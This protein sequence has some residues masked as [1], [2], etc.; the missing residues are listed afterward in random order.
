MSLW[1]VLL[2]GDRPVRLEKNE[3]TVCWQMIWGGNSTVR[4]YKI[5]TY[6]YVTLLT[7]ESR[8]SRPCKLIDKNIA[9]EFSN[10]INH[11]QSGWNILLHRKGG[12]LMHKCYLLVGLGKWVEWTENL[13]WTI[14]IYRLEYEW[15]NVPWRN[16][17]N[18]SLRR[19]LKI[20]ILMFCFYLLIGLRSFHTVSPDNPPPTLGSPRVCA[21]MIVPLYLPTFCT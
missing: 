5:K 11:H 13:V 12:M 16:I 15:R 21:Q 3:T 17:H 2:L 6:Q 4:M 8:K 19:S 10:S 9:R 1:T 20:L 14:W 7:G 18:N